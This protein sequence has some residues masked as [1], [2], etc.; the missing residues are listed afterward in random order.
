MLNSVEW[1]EEVY[2]KDLFTIKRGKRLTVENRVKGNRPLITAGYENTGVAEFIGNNNQEIFPE[3]TIT[4]DMF[5]NTFYRNYSYSADDN[6]L[7][8]FDKEKIPSKAK[9]FIVGLINKVLSTKF[10]YGKQYRMGSFEETKIQLP[11]KNG[12]IN[13]SFMEKFIAELEAEH[14][15]ELEAYLVATGLKDHTLTVKEQQVLDDFENGKITFKEF[16]YESIFNKIV[17]GR[18]LT[19]NDQISGDIPF[20]MAGTTNT[21][22]VNY[23]S[24]PVASFPKNSIT[25]DIFGNTFYRSYNF[26]AGDDTGV[27]WSDEKNYSKETMLFFAASMGKSLFGKF[28]FGK[29]LRSSQSLNFKMKLPFINKQPNYIIME[30]FISAIQKLVIKDVVLY[31]DKKI[32]TTK[33]VVEKEI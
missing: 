4:I 2:L 30:T 9:N 16:T 11:I 25:I 12:K 31:A 14:I 6:I 8:L 17:Q 20:V 24:N 26:G 3:D 5:A 21:G 19:K 28:D 10:S 7:V 23:I 27:Y 18:R 33:S 22:V 29:K 15:A 1:G 32:A 13:F